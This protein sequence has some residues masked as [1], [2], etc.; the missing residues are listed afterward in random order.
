MRAPDGHQ[1]QPGGNAL[2]PTRSMRTS[3][4]FAAGGPTIPLVSDYRVCN[5]IIYQWFAGDSHPTFGRPQ[6]LLASGFLASDLV[7]AHRFPPEN[8]PKGFQT[9][10]E[11][12][13]LV[14]K[15]LMM[16]WVLP[17]LPG[18]R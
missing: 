9:L 7:V 1:G 4:P 10:P 5:N 17:T 14:I 11:R 13:E 6:R 12:P 8:T 18:L 16:P 15:V 2:L 3:P